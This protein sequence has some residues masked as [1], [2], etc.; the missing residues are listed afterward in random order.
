MVL[1]CTNSPTPS[2]DFIKHAIC[3]SFDNEKGHVMIET[4]LINRKRLREI[5]PAS[6]MTVWRWVKAG[7]FPAPVKIRSR[8]YWKNSDIQE[9]L[10]KISDDP[11]SES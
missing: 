11:A 7:I 6:D 1:F 8:C 10:S 3:P 5:V 9:W 4:K 2:P